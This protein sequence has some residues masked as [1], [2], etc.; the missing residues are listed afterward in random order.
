M[1]IFR[2]FD[3][4][5]PSS[6]DEA[7][8]ML[9]TR[10][11]SALLAGGTDLLV[12][13]QDGKLAHS[14]LIS[15]TG[16]PGLDGIAYNGDYLRMGAMVTH[17][18]IENSALIR[19]DFAVLADAVREVGSPQVRNVGTIGGNLCNAAP[20]ADAATPL[21]ALNASV[22]LVGPAGERTLS[23]ESFFTGPLKT[24]LQPGEIMTEI[25]LPKLP[26]VS[27]GAFIKHAVR[28]AM[29]LALVSVSVVVTLDASESCTD[30]R[31]AMGVVAPVPMRARKA[32]AL[33]IGGKVD[34][35][36]A[37]Q[38]GVTAAEEARPRTSFRAS[39]EYRR[40]V[41]KVLV[42][43]AVNMALGRASLAT[44]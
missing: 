30:A 26:A 32:E 3:Y 21:L 20:S 37:E 11:G 19:R 14:A 40:E 33:L 42:R 17:A 9:T 44:A 35:A 31:I 15:L 18:D 23:L 1:G 2:K 7:I 12:K 29:E 39:A 16:I 13:M 43:R 8:R 4:L 34:N 28:S 10:E 22:K 36:L 41:L 27:A 25:I 38:A 6:L 24:V 5:E